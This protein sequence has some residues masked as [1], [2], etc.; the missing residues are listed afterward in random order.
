MIEMHF[1]YNVTLKIGNLD[2]GSIKSDSIKEINFTS[3]DFIA[4]DDCAHSC[5]TL[6]EGYAAKLSDDDQ[7]KLGTEINPIHSGTP[8]LSKNWDASEVARLWVY[9]RRMEGT[10]SIVAVAQAHIFAIS[11]HNQFAKALN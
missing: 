10:G 9:D 2:L 7:F 11:D 6:M 1:R 4:F 3:R 8:T 5:R